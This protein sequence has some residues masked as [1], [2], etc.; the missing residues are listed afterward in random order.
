MSPSRLDRFDPSVLESFRVQPPQC[1]RT[2]RLVPICVRQREEGQDGD[3]RAVHFQTGD[4]LTAVE[5]GGGTYLSRI[6]Y[7]VVLRWSPDGSPV[8]RGGPTAAGA[9]GAGADGAGAKRGK[10]AGAGASGDP[11]QERLGQLGLMRGMHR[12][13]HPTTRHE[14]TPEQLRI[15]PMHL[16]MQGF[17]ETFFSGP[18]VQWP[19]Y[20]W[21]AVRFGLMF[22]C[23]QSLSGSAISGLEE[24]LRIFEVLE[25]Q[26]GLL[27]FIGDTFSTAFI[28]PHPDDYR[29]LHERLIEDFYQT[30]FG[31]YADLPIKAAPWNVTMDGEA[32]TFADL[33]ASL[34]RMRATWGE[35]GLQATGDLMVPWELEERYQ[36][37]PFR[38][39]RFHTGFLPDRQNHIGECVLR[40]DGRI[41]W[42][43]TFPLSDTQS[44]F[45]WFLHHL[46]RHDWHL[47]RSAEAMGIDRREIIRRMHRVGLSRIIRRDV[48]AAALKG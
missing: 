8:G 32:R 18:T 13:L 35:A 4:D 26:C 5:V 19:E 45:A 38:L 15:L 7:G 17:L 47:D 41:G 48:L 34:A 22:R 36:A 42:L 29:P 40:P 1:F 20:D 3:L 11:W 9:N 2:I 33:R 27:I 21:R 24:A 39:H 43:K 31:W 14:D 28:A 46:S 10:R 23:E 30:H 37:G 16:A 25:D 44:A 12:R 6:P